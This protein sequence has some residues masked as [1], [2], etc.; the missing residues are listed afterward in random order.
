MYQKLASCDDN[1][2]I[3]VWMNHGTDESWCEE[4]LNNRHKSNV[5][6]L[7]WSNDGS[8]IAIAY[9]DGKWVGGVPFNLWFNVV[10]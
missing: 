4:M 10:P 7:K 3:I 1:G 8:K 6:S 9:E 5:V 2:L